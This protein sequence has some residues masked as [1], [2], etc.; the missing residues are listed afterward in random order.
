MAQEQV[1]KTKNRFRL[2]RKV[3]EK[4]TLSATT[5]FGYDKLEIG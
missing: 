1:T 5:F 2:F 4:N 3:G